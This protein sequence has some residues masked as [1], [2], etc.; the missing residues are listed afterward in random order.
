M[1]GQRTLPTLGLTAWKNRLV[2]ALADRCVR[3]SRR[4]PRDSADAE[5]MLFDQIER[6]CDTCRQ[7]QLIEL[8]VESPHWYQNLVLRPE[9]FVAMTVS[10]ARKAV[11]ER[12]LLDEELT[13]HEPTRTVLMT[14]TAARLPGLM[15]VLR[16]NLNN[17]AQITVLPANAVARASHELA[18]CLRRGELPRTTFDLSIPLIRGRE[19][20]ADAFPGIDPMLRT[21]A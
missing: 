14:A 15:D 21:G 9:E 12:Q 20:D 16:D 6:A 13:L 1:L 18:V 10:L 7:N 11:L 19:S 17:E 5:Q 4:D 2:D 3:Q 8:A